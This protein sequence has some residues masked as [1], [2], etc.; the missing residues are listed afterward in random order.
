MLAVRAH[1]L[2]I[3]IMT[4]AI[5]MPEMIPENGP[6]LAYG[7]LL[8]DLGGLRELDAE[9]PIIGE[10]S[11]DDMP[12]RY[13]QSPPDWV[14]P[15]WR[16]ATLPVREYNAG[17]LELEGV[18]FSDEDAI[19]SLTANGQFESANWF[20][21]NPTNFVPGWFFDAR[22]GKLSLYKDIRKRKHG[23]ELSSLEF[24]AKNVDPK[25]INE[26]NNRVSDIIFDEQSVIITDLLNRAT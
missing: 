24:Y 12:P 20:V 2:T 10:F 18:E 16:G 17:I 4:L 21:E 19:L 23:T 15:G 5:P 11:L 14:A 25:F 1:S 8:I 13:K 9:F 7:T 26:L 6:K 22:I 3:S